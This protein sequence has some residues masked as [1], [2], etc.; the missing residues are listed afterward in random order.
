MFIPQ[1]QSA[2][3]LHMF[4]TAC[5]KAKVQVLELLEEPTRLPSCQAVLLEKTTY[6]LSRG[7]ARI[8]QPPECAL[9]FLK[10]FK[11]LITIGYEDF[12]ETRTGPF[13]AIGSAAI[14]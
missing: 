6:F 2:Q 11:P 13:V 4:S 3:V 12:T 14:V 9:N 10:L 5:G 1:S 8:S 7:S